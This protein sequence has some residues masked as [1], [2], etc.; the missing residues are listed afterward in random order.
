MAERMAHAIEAT[1]ARE[2]ELQKETEEL[3]KKLERLEQK[4]T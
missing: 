2:A 4:I 3:K 1:K